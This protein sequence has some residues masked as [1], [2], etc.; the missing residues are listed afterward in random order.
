M[1]YGL[2]PGRYP[3]V[4]EQYEAET[5]LCR[6]KIDGLTDGA[7]TLPLAEIEYPI[8]D[9]S[10]HGAYPTEIEILPGDLVWVAFIGGDSR[11][12]IVTGYRNP[13]QG[14]V[15]DW[16]RWHQVNIELLA[17]QLLRLIA[18]SSVQIEAGQEVTITAPLTRIIGNLQVVGNVH[19][20]G[21]IIDT[22]G[23]T[24]HHSH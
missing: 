22:T 19:A 24:N 1:D 17:D 12:P 20:T 15:V 13:R 21:S 8:G 16:R 6:V 23:N 7:D 11:Y 4:I 18:G 3:G 2:M 14:N 10:K 5:R 9:K